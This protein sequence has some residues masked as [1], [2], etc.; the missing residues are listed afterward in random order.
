MQQKSP[1]QAVRGMRDVFAPEAL[2]YQQLVEKIHHLLQQHGYNP[3][4]LPLLEKTHLFARTIGE[5]TDIVSKEMYTFLDRNEESLTLRPEGTAGVARALIQHG[6]L[7][8]VQRV[9]VEGPMFRYERPQKGRYRQFSQ[10]SVEAFGMTSPAL[11]V[12]LIGI[13]AELFAQLGV[14]DKVRLE[15]NSIGL[16]EERRAFQKDLVEYL[17]AHETQL[18][19]DSRRRLHTNPLRILD[20]KNEAVQRI[21]DNAPSLSTYL[22]D[23]SHA[24]YQQVRELL[25]ALG[26]EYVENPRLVRGL[27]Y[28]CH[29]VFEWVTEELGAQG[30]ICAGGRYD[31]LTEQLGGA[32]TPAAGFAFGLERI[33]LLSQAY[34][35]RATGISVYAIAADEQA[36]A[37]LMVTLRKLR[38]S[39]PALSITLHTE[40]QSLKNQLK[41]ADKSGAD[42]A[43]IVGEQERETDTLTLK[44]LANGEQVRV[45]LTEGI[46]ILEKGRV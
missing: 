38:Q 1:I 14:L 36:F 7:Q 13:A 23:A 43:L 27:D 45:G 20:S 42:F 12:E 6:M 2:Y 3:A 30:T 29:T 11:D 25:E 44:N 17:S 46:A 26:I 35:E 5:E 39:I 31:G 15:I 8:Q 9:Y 41:K 24:H 40:R 18:D 16:A 37:P 32:H 22:S 4:Q 33:A 28:Y 10:I 34:F 19:E 21:L